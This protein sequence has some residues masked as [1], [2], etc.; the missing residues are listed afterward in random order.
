MCIQITIPLVAARPVW[1]EMLVGY[2]QESWVESILS[3]QR[4][5]GNVFFCSH[6]GDD[7]SDM[8]VAG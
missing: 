8:M 4:I 1:A 3:T 7:R 5:V 6:G 2:I